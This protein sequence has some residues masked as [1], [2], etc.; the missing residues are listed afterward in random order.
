MGFN[1]SMFPIEKPPCVKQIPLSENAHVTKNRVRRLS[2][3]QLV[4]D[5]ERLESGAPLLRWSEAPRRPQDGDGLKMLV[6]KYCFWVRRLIVEWHRVSPVTGNLV[7]SNVSARMVS[8]M[9]T[10]LS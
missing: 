8:R 2:R 3:C 4:D 1:T 6:E 5:A 10:T 9:A 7:H